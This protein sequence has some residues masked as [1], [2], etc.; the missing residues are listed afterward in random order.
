MSIELGIEILILIEVTQNC[1]YRL[2]R[3]IISTELGIE[4]LILIEVTQKSKYRLKWSIILFYRPRYRN[5]L[6]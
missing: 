2:D 5:T 4:I 1:K 6:Y 3:G